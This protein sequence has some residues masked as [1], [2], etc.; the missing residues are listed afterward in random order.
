MIER[1]EIDLDNCNPTSIWQEYQRGI[2]YNRRK[3]LYTN[4]D[5]NYNFFH[6][7]QW[8]KAKLGDMSPIVINVIKPIVKYKVGVINQNA[9]SVV[10]SPSYLESN[11]KE[12]NKLCELLS[13]HTDR[14]FENQ[15]I[16][17]KLRTIVKD[18]CINSEGIF[19][20]YFDENEG[21]D[22]EV[23]GEIVDK[24]NI[25]YGDETNENI[26][27]QPYIIIAFRKPVTVVKEEALLKGVSKENI[28][29]IVSD[30]EKKERAG[31]TNNTNNEELTPMCLE[32]LKLYKK[33]NADGVKTV[34]FTKC[35]K[36]VEIEKEQDTK[37]KLYPVAHFVWEEEKGNARGMGDVEPNI[38]NQIEINKTEMRR[39]I[40]VKN[41]AYPK[42]A[43]NK[44]YVKDLTSLNKVGASIEVEGAGLDDIRKYI[45]YINGTSMSPDSKYLLDELVNYTQN[46]AG[47]GDNASGNIDVTKTSARAILAVQQAQEQPLNE[48]LYRFKEFLENI[49]RIYLDMIQ[50]YMIDGLVISDE[51]EQQV[52]DENGN[53]S[54]ETVTVGIP[55]SYEALNELKTNVKVDITPTTPFS[56]MDMEQSLENLFTAD[57]ITFEEWVNALPYDSSYPKKRL[58]EIIKQ[59]EQTK[60]DIS[61]MQQNAQSQMMQI[62]GLLNQQARQEDISNIANQGN[63]NIRQF[64]N[65]LQ[66]VGGQG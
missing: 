20:M 57:K 18:A 5:R 61:I 8:E 66:Q 16:T 64:Q 22:G 42:L 2:N 54:T 35:T 15:N 38:P 36:F 63:E 21:R 39:A 1:E 62:Q 33:V 27:E 6:G 44:S 31:Y 12:A 40:I 9:Y 49:A 28:D 10:F 47:A 53:V 19:F 24:N 51:Q 34:H 32:L 50:N 3:N 26:E 56:K 23:V 65:Y 55:V 52:L 13:K 37:M 45:G 30:E 43:Y 41:S 17:S 14:F 7:K 4:T 46:L 60:K 11:A 58:E 48:Q 29:L 25:Y 59:R